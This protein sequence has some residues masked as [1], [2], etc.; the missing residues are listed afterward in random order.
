MCGA[1]PPMMA[2]AA[3]AEGSEEKGSDN[4]N[5]IDGVNWK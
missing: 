3:Y 5:V 2:I 1:S 4:Q